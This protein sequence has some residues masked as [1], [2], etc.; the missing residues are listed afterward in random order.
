MYVEKHDLLDFT[1][2]INYSCLGISYVNEIDLLGFISNI[3][4]HSAL[5]SSL[6]WTGDKCRE[7]YLIP[8]LAIAETWGKCT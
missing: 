5:H 6:L 1:L 2:N 8:T 7:V 4:Y 3:I